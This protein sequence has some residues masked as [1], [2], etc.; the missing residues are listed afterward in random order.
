[1]SPRLVHVPLGLPSVARGLV[2][3]ALRLA[4]MSLGL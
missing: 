1:M 2:R 4:S 3:V